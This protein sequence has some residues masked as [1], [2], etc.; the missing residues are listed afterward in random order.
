MSD[1]GRCAFWAATTTST[2]SAGASLTPSPSVQVTR[3]ELI[4]RV[5]HGIKYINF[6]RDKRVHIAGTT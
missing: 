1:V 5:L 3:D 4:A 2:P 6:L